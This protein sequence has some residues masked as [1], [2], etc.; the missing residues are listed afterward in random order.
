[1]ETEKGKVNDPLQCGAE[2]SF[3]VGEKLE[4]VLIPVDPM[5]E[6]ASRAPVYQPPRPLRSM[7][8]TAAMAGLVLPDPV[9][10]R[11]KAGVG[12]LLSLDGSDLMGHEEVLLSDEG[13][14]V[15]HGKGVDRSVRDPM[16]VEVSLASWPLRCVPVLPAVALQHGLAARAQEVEEAFVVPTGVTGASLGTEVLVVVASGVPVSGAG[17]GVVE[18]GELLPF[19]QSSKTGLG[20]AEHALQC[21]DGSHAQ[22]ELPA[23]SVEVASSSAGPLVDLGPEWG[24]G[25]Q[26]LEVGPTE[27]CGGGLPFDLNFLCQPDELSVPV[28]SASADVVPSTGGLDPVLHV[29][30]VPARQGDAEAVVTTKAGREGNRGT[31][32]VLARLAVPLK[33]SLLCSPMVLKP[34]ASVSKKNSGVVSAAPGERKSGRAPRKQGVSA[35]IEEQ[36]TGLLMRTSGVLGENGMPSEHDKEN[37]S[38]Q[39][40]V[41]LMQDVV[42]GM[43]AVFGLPEEGGANSMGA[44]VHDGD[45]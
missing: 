6:E 18:E 29:V 21:R 43:R 8:P 31:S 17:E 32:C 33:K 26:M 4:Q 23:G 7:E 42:G 15:L 9:G 44:L 1:V 25:E 41:P 39:F 24:L 36:A 14:Q 35:T 2:D 10:L 11:S 12:A 28:A 45:D 19:C 16:L 13:V 34:K 30:V 38:G 3:L 20:A 5:V 37:F 27:S 22:L 40:F